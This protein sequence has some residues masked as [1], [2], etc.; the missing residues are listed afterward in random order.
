M[1]SFIMA[2]AVFIGLFIIVLAAIAFSGA[3]DG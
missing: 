2:V 1:V 3:I